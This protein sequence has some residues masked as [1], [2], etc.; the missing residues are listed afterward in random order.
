MLI[1]IIPVG[2]QNWYTGDMMHT[3]CHGCSQC[4]HGVVTG[5]SN[6]ALELWNQARLTRVYKRGEI[7]FRQGEP[8]AGV[9]CTSSGLTKLYRSSLSGE[10]QILGLVGGLQVLGHCSLLCDQPVASTAEVVK[11]AK[12]CFVDRQTVLQC[13][14]LDARLSI[15]LSRLLARQ[16]ANAENRLFSVACLSVRARLAGLLLETIPEDAAPVQLTR[17]EMA[18]IIGTKPESVSRGLHE[19]AKM[20]VIRLEK[21][22][23][24]ILDRRPLEKLT[25]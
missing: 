19:L 18:Q 5:T 20:A 23:I 12:I 13:M 4:G 16:L 2:D 11:E 15:N 10:T 24:E 9:F 25:L 7:L 22:R 14:A 1:W 3:G 21:R 8:S 6:Q 17:G